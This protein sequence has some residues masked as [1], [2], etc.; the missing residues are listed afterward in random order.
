MDFINVLRDKGIKVYVTDLNVV[1]D[2]E[3]RAPEN[4]SSK[5]EIRAH[6]VWFNCWLSAI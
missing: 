2:K 1:G 6:I 3:I 4:Q 5:K